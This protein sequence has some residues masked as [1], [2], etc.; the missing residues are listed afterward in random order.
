[1]RMPL[2]RPVRVALV[3]PALVALSGCDIAMADLKI[4]ETAEWRK[5]Y[6]LQ[7]GGRVEISN[8]NGRIQVEPSGNNTVEVVAVK[9]ARGATSEAAKESLGR[10][11]ITEESSPASVR[12]ETKIQRGSGMFNHGGGEVA[13]TVRVPSGADLKF[14]TVNGGIDVE[15]VSGRISVE[16]V[17]GGIVARD[18]D[19]GSLAATTVNGGVEVA[20][21]RM[22]DGGVK[23]GCTNGGIKVRLPADAKADISVRVVNGGIDVDADALRIQSSE[24]SRR[25]FE[26]RMNGGGPRM[27]IEGTN[28]G[29]QISAR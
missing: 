19:A 25:R 18:V 8:V 23:L 16:T 1:M 13:Y 14:T 9:T 27:D 26:G 20:L 17:N 4:K 6:D 24:K 29:I 21:S 3:I 11:E 7:P 10:I 22:P 28:G 5:S 12:I 2:S 15:R